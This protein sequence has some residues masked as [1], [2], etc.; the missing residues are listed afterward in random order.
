MSAFFTALLIGSVAGGIA[1]ALVGKPYEKHLRYLVALLCTA[2]VATPLIAFVGDVELKPPRGDDISAED[3]A[4]ELV[5]QK[6]AADSQAAVAEY[7]F[8]KTGIKVKDI[9]IQ[10][11]SVEGTLYFRKVRV[12]TEKH[13]VPTVHSCLKELI[14][15]EMEIEVSG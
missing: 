13:Q 5:I 3:R 14:G 8:G 4:Q 15:A 12:Q 6:A 7:I 11:E 2:L 9:S 1:T 10:I